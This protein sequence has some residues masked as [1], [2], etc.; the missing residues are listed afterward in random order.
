[1]VQIELFI[2]KTFSVVA[3]YIH[4]VLVL[5]IVIFVQ[6]VLDCLPVSHSVALSECACVRFVKTRKKSK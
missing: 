6:N 3:Q 4:Y 5:L 1:M 2:Y